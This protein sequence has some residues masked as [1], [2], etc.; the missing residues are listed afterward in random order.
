MA[1]MHAFSNSVTGP[2]LLN[3]FTP[4]GASAGT[5]TIKMYQDSIGIAYGWKF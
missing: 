2:S 3:N 1:Y 4:P 5:E